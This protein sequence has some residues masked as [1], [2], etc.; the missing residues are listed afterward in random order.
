M[1]L[2]SNLFCDSR[3]IPKIACTTPE[4][5]LSVASFYLLIVHAVQDWNCMTAGALDEVAKDL[6]YSSTIKDGCTCPYGVTFYVHNI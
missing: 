4:S 2:L 6:V 5:I 1:A 3:K